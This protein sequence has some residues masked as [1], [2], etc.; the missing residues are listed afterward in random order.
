MEALIALSILSIALSA[1][2]AAQNASR[3]RAEANRQRRV[4]QEQG[5]ERRQQLVDE[6]KRQKFGVTSLFLRP[7]DEPVTV[8][9]LRMGN[10][11]PKTLSVGARS[12]LNIPTLMG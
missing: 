11:P 8:E 1:G 4:V 10:A 6:R 5:N 9:S 12:G 7:D 2:M 3:Q